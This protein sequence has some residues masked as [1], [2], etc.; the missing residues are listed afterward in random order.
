MILLAVELPGDGWSEADRIQV[1]RHV[2]PG[3]V[4]CRRHQVAEV[5]DVVGDR[6]GQCRSRPADDQRDANAALVKIPFHAAQRTAG[7]VGV[8]ALVIA[9]YEDLPLPRYKYARLDLGGL[10]VPESLAIGVV[11]DGNLSVIDREGRIDV[12]SMRY[13]GAV[14]NE[15]AAKARVP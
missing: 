15:I 14:A 4:G 5:P 12:T 1:G 2:D 3:P 9:H 10:A 6:A 11:G 13:H 8:V 7:H